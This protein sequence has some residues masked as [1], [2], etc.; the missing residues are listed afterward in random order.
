M[1]STNCNPSLQQSRMQCIIQEMSWYKS[2]IRMEKI[3][4]IFTDVWEYVDD[5]GNVVQH[6]M[7]MKKDTIYQ[8]RKR[9]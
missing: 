4:N 3:E 9:S 1:A 7:D 5:R 2:K 6:W 8:I